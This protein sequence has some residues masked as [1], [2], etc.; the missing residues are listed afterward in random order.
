MYDHALS[1]LEPSMS[2]P[3]ERPPVVVEGGAADTESKLLVRHLA[4]DDDAFAEL[5]Q[6]YRAPVF[7]YLIRSGVGPDDRDD[8]FQEIFIHRAAAS[9]DPGRSL[10]PWL[11]TIVANTVRN[12]LRR[13]RVQAV[14]GSVEEVAEPPA[15]N[16]G[17][18]RVAA[19]KQTMTW[20]E[21]QIRRLPAARREVL[22]L[23]CV[24]HLP[25]KQ[26][27][28]VLGLPLG[29]VKTHLRRARLSLAEEL[30]RRNSPE[31]SS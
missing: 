21:R 18:D 26:V 19:G 11:F 6:R 27:A 1:A 3:A 9:Y 8:L 13:Q 14:V 4:G 5:V 24:E 30:A 22:I 28:D 10:H 7:S 15:T 2:G 17:A 16:P 31:V 29:T 12:H 23:V 20:L 25:L